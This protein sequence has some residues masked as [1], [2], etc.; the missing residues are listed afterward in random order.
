MERRDDCLSLEEGLTVNSSASADAVI[1]DIEA[2]VA[3]AACS[4]MENHNNM[5]QEEEE[6]EEEEE[7]NIDLLHDDSD[8]A[9]RLRL[10]PNIEKLSVDDLLQKWVGE[11]GRAQLWHF[12]LVSLAW[13]IH[14]LQT[15]AMVFADRQPSWQCRSSPSQPLTSASTSFS[16]AALNITATGDDR[17]SHEVWTSPLHDR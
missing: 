1:M 17:S 11:C 5:L 13:T 7:H 6:E 12:V 8:A 15:F 14:G 9:R 10:V 4:T 16:N 3:A 2:A